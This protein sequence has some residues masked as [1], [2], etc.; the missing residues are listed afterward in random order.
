MDLGPFIT[1]HRPAGLGPQGFAT[2]PQ[3]SDPQGSLVMTTDLGPQGFPHGGKGLEP[4]S[5]DLG[6]W[7][8]GKIYRYRAGK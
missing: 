8:L 3:G 7:F 6:P 5:L 2:G 4:L 1:A